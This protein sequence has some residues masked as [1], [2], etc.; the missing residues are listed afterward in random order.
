MPHRV[1]RRLALLI[2]L[3]ATAGG[4]AIAQ[5]QPE[6]ILPPGFGEPAAPPP[7]P[8]SAPAQQAPA[9]ATTRP[10]S[11]DLSRL[12]DVIES[13][14]S[15][16]EEGLVEIPPPIEYR[17]DRRRDPAMVGILSTESLGIGTTPW[18]SAGGNFLSILLRRTDVP[19][20]SRWA[21]IGLRNILLARTA[22]PGLINPADWVAE[23]AWLLLRL[24]EAD[25]ARLLVAG[26]D[27]D[28]FTPK[29]AQV[30]AQ[31][32][33]AS[34]DPSG[35]C[36]I[37]AQLPE[38]EP[39]I[40]PL[41]TAMCASLA[42]EAE[43]AA[44]DIDSARRRGRFAEIDLALADKVVGAGA[45][46]AR[47]VTIEWE[48]VNALNIWRYGLSTATGMMP[49][50]RLI[51]RADP[52][53]RAWLAR[54]PMFSA[55]QRMNAAR[56]AAALGVMSSDAMVDLY[57]LAYDA[58]DPDEL[59]GSDPWK[60]RQAFVGA[61]R[62]ARL[63]ALRQLWGDAND[64]ERQMAGWVTTARAATLVAPSA[65][66]Q[67]DAANLIAAML[68]GGYDRQAARW[69]AAV[70]EMDDEA[71]DRAWAM[72]ALGVAD[73]G[74]LEID[75]GRIEEFAG[76]DASPGKRR[77]RLLI[78]GLAGLGRIDA[79]TAGQLNQ[80][81]RLGLERETTWTRLID[82]AARRRQAGTVMI[83]S[84]SAMQAPSIGDVPA[85]YLFH[86][87][88]A[89]R[90]TGQEAMARMIAAEALART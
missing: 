29:L 18:G 32:A 71:G 30:A 85:L 11:P 63:T 61:D 51:E 2:A 56:T 33:L 28:R 8:V 34:G 19:L 27:T 77:T 21:Q 9:P 78:A 42:G 80:R 25:A 73:A 37:E 90:R 46:T 44:A 45:N 53:L 54:A 74:P 50:E 6:S 23:R 49:P 59:G 64:P 76:R 43:R 13:E 20:A 86:A 41:V 35:L 47:A 69:T 22:A 40:A 67:E 55:S 4:A 7:P 88:T 38:V 1:N 52:Q 84:A 48:P 83:L 89:L 3:A 70:A 24:G 57:S 87:A 26:I 16:D 68:A 10:R 31:V 82:G 75:R 65:E 15:G 58:I 60:L 14:T 36:A 17:D 81:Y 72:L 79:Q 5:D 66:L 12:E 39:R 62:N